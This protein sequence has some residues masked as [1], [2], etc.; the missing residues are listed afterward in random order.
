M[1]EVAGADDLPGVLVGVIVPPLAGLEVVL[2]P[3]ALTG[4][5]DPLV[6]VRAEAVHVAGI[7]RNTPVPHEVGDLMCGLG[8]ARPEVPLHVRAAQPVGQTLLR[9]DEIGELHAVTQ[10]E[11][12]GV[13]ADDVVVSLAG[14]ELQREAADVADGVGETLLAGDGRETA[15]HRGDAARLEQVGLR[16]GGDVLGDRQFTEGAGAL[17]V[18]VALR[19]AL[20]VEVGVLLDEVCVGEGDGALFPDG[21]RVLFGPHRRAVDVRRRACVGADAA[22]GDLGGCGVGHG[23]LLSSCGFVF[24]LPLYADY[25]N[26]Q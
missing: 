3:E 26:G 13:V 18:D 21:H 9:A 16:V 8:T 5:V 17:G 12:R 4:G 6:G 19:D 22:G 7:R 20:P 14:V 25:R 11:H 10:E 24:R 15:E 2:H 1:V 23:L